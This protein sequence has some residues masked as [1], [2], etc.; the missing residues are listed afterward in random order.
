MDT[1]ETGNLEIV[2]RDFAD[3]PQQVLLELT[4]GKGRVIKAL[5]V[6]GQDSLVIESLR[7][8]TFKL[9]AIEDRNKDGRWTPANYDTK[10]QAEPVFRYS[11]EIDIRAGWDLAVEFEINLPPEEKK[12]PDK[13]A[14]EE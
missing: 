4:D 1:D 2:F 13:P 9:R 6:N 12:R 7:P 5:S 3:T 14:S 10:I 8:G 11:E